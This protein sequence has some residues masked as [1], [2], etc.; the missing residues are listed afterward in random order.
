MDEQEKGIKYKLRDHEYRKTTGPT[1]MTSFRVLIK[2]TDLLISA[3]QDLSKQARDSV[4]HYRRQLEDYIK[5]KP[6]FLSTLLPFSQDV[7]APPIVKEMTYASSIFNVGPMASV[8]GTIA[9]FVGNDLLK[10]SDEVIIENG[11]DI[12]LKVN[13]TA[14]ASIFAGNSRLNRKIG[15]IIHPEQTPAGVCTSSA[16]IGHSLSFGIADAVCIV[17]KSSSIA[18]AAATALCNRITTKSK[19]EKEIELFKNSA[20]ISGGAV[21]LKNTLASW[22]D[23]ELTSAN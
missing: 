8:A 22:G 4:F 17:A 1:G 6:V 3:C 9:Q 23:I 12:F 16:T 13:R 14:T 7:F 10:Y 21:I 19:M 18:D 11:G 20:H 5:K 2:E 15:I